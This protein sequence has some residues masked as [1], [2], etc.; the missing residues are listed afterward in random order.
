MNESSKPSLIKPIKDGVQKYQ[1]AYYYSFSLIL[2]KKSL[3]I[4]F[5]ICTCILFRKKHAYSGYARLKKLTLWNC[6][7][8]QAG[9]NTGTIPTHSDLLKIRYKNLFHNQLF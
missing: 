3:G 6:K 2:I 8:K 4:D 9:I 7:I 5:I 1:N